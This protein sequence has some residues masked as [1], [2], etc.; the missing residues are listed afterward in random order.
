MDFV[1]ALL[2][3]NN[4]SKTSDQL[5]AS[6]GYY[7]TVKGQWNTDLMKKSDFPLDMLPEV[8]ASSEDAGLLSHSWFD[9]PS[10][11][12]IGVALGDLQCSVRSTLIDAKT[13]AVLNVSTSA[14]LAFVKEEG[15]QPAIEVRNPEK[16]INLSSMSDQTADFSTD[17]H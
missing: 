1:V 13:D 7:N 6:W 17:S 14:Q 3:N 2:C 15:F 4:V 12:P 8:L 11:T 5:A 16:S 9:I 10:G